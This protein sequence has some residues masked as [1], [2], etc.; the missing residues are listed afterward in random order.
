MPCTHMKKL[1]QL[2]DQY[3][4]KLASSDLI[5]VLCPHC[6]VEETCPSRMMD[7]PEIDDDPIESNPARPTR[8]T[9]ESDS[10]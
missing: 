1:Y 4:M 10:R 7:E 5:R 8:P 3:D 2:V 6:Q 9:D